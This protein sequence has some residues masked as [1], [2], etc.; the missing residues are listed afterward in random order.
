VNHFL[1]ELLDGLHGSC[2]AADEREIAK[3]HK[4]SEHWEKGQCILHDAF[5]ASESVAVIR[6][7]E[8]DEPITAILVISEH[9]ALEFFAESIAVDLDFA[10]AP[11]QV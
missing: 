3:E 4:P 8:T 1:A 2:L 9:N 7:A 6:K 11:L 5:H 10:M